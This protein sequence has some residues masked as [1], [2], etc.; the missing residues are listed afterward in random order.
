M[1]NTEK[2]SDWLQVIGMFGVIASLV[3]VG[4]QM[5]QTHEIALSETYQARAAASIEMNM[6]VTNSPELLSGMA[7]IYSN[8]LES[9]TS[10]EAIALEYLSGANVIMYENH[11]FQYESGFLPEEHWQKNIRD[12]KCWFEL[13]FFRQQIE[14]WEFRESFTKVL[15]DIVSESISKPSGCWDFD[16]D[17]PIQN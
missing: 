14:T 6:T 2:L 7:K 15:E 4:F 3:F 11:H 12:M 9:M 10:Q 13:P 1:L 5:K 17:Y 16:W 8:Q